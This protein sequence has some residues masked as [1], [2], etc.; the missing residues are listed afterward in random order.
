[1]AEKKNCKENGR[2]CSMPKSN[3]SNVRS[4][5]I[6][7]FFVFCAT[8]AFTQNAV[9]GWKDYK[10]Q[11]YGISFK[12][13][14]DFYITWEGD[15]RS[16]NPPTLSHVIDISKYKEAPHRDYPGIRIVIEKFDGNLNSY[17]E[18]RLTEIRF[19]GEADVVL[20]AIAIGNI[21]GFE[22]GTNIIFIENGYIFNVNNG[23]TEDIFLLF[24]QT[25]EVKAK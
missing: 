1:M 2:N 11:A 3:D 17:L 7:I 21:Y 24:M 16:P 10:N 25:I 18:Q 19:E 14:P 12:I 4:L 6:V 22:L 23:I 20:K 9:S 8:N 13:P 5:I 15:W